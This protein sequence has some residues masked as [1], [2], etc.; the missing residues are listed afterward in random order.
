MKGIP[1]AASMIGESAIATVLELR[2]WTVW[3]DS[4]HV[5]GMKLKGTLSHVKS[6]LVHGRALEKIIRWQDIYTL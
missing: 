6:E 3:T 2:G 4:L 5:N 1:I